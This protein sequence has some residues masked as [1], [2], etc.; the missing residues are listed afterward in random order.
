MSADAE[1]PA[2]NC[3]GCLEAFKRAI[4]GHVSTKHLQVKQSVQLQD[5]LQLHRTHQDGGIQ[6]RVDKSQEERFVRTVAVW[7]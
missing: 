4:Q 2:G 7:P 6:P 5:M 3:S 1:G